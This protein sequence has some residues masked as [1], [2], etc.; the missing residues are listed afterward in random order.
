M[1]F[2]MSIAVVGAFALIAHTF[3][4][5]EGSATIEDVLRAIWNG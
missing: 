2:L 1:K 4:Q 3:G 5:H